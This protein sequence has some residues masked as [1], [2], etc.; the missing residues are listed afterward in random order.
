MHGHLE[1]IENHH[2]H[3]CGLSIHRK[4]SADRS[5][6]PAVLCQCHLL[7]NS[8]HWPYLGHNNTSIQFKMSPNPITCS[9]S[10]D[11]PPHLLMAIAFGH[12][13]PCNIGRQL[14][15]ERPGPS[16]LLTHNHQGI[17]QSPWHVYLTLIDWR[18]FLTLTVINLCTVVSPWQQ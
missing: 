7:P 1:S 12:N 14:S 3:F 2:W 11:H 4:S 9:S 17:T 16:R 8:P 15:P 18:I 5:S 13:K 10:H 6:A